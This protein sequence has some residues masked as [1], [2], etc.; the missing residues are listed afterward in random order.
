MPRLLVIDDDHL[1]CMIICRIAAKAGFAPQ[2]AAS[3]DEAAKLA[4]E[5]TF[6]CITLDLSLGAHAGVEMLRHLWVLRCKAPIIIIT[7]CDD[8]VCRETVR[9]GKSLNLNVW[10]PVPKPVDLAMLR[11][12]LEQL[13]IEL[14]HTSVSV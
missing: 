3:Y 7:G 2:A 9:I 1:H 8:V 12:S 5:A 4:Q 14:E 6:D 10:E 13:K 11:H